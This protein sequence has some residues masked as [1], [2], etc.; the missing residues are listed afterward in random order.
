MTVAL[1]SRGGKARAQKSRPT[2]KP[3]DNLNPKSKRAHQSDAVE[4]LL[5]KWRSTYPKMT[6][7]WNGVGIAL[8]V[9]AHQKKIARECGAALTDGV[10]R[11][12]PT[13]SQDKIDRILQHFR[14]SVWREHA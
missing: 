5:D 14:A 8:S 13:A 7:E 10:W 6:R 12:P 1:T 11:I 4:Q 9:R 2:Q 3:K